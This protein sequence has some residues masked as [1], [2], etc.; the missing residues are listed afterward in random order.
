MRPLRAL[1]TLPI[2][3]IALLGALG[4]VGAASAE[5]WR[6]DEQA[7]AFAVLTHRAGFASGLAHDHL[8]VA[9]AAKVEFDLDP[10]RPEAARL[11]LEARADALEVDGAAARERWG[12]RL[13]ELGALGEE[14]LP[15]VPE[16]DG[17]KVRE[18]MLGRS[19]LDAA[20]HPTISAE[21]VGL[22]RRGGGGDGERTALGWTAKV[23]LTVRG[24]SVERELA[25]TWSLEG[26]RLTAEGLGEARFTELGIEPYS[27][28]LGAVKNTDLFHLYVALAAERVA[29]DAAPPDEP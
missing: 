8:I 20:S 29:G 28:F 1:T 11:A 15:P 21:L 5:G 10:E 6:V 27:A 24:R 23:R 12:P 4:A 14:G 18:A 26:D 17:V 25:L 16:K 7:T 19:Q 2:A 22:A 9:R 3:L 13:V